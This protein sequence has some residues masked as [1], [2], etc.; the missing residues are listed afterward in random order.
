MYT[1]VVFIAEFVAQLVPNIIVLT[2]NVMGTYSMGIA[3]EL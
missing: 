3:T 1:N 2:F